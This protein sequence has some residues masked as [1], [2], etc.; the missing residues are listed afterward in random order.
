M[1]V[2]AILGSLGKSSRN[3]AL[4]EQLAGVAN[5]HDVERCTSLGELPFFD[6]DVEPEDAPA[7]VLALRASIARAD[8]VFIACPEYGHSLPGVLKN[9]IDWV[10]GSGELERK[11]VAITASVP[12]VERGRRGLAALAQTLGAVS[13]EIVWDEPI[14]RGTEDEALA[15]VLTALSAAMSRRA[16]TP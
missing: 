8:A 1:R 7:V 16:P 3:L 5:G 12:H 11:V 13:A 15:Q 10:I 9:A 14:L 4:L 6:P 2:L